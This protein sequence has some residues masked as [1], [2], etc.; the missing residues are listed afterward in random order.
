MTTYTEQ[1]LREYVT[2]RSDKIHADA[3]AAIAVRPK[4]MDRKQMEQELEKSNQRIG[5]RDELAE[6]VDWLNRGGQKQQTPKPKCE[7]CNDTKEVSAPHYSSKG[8]VP[9]CD[10]IKCPKCGV[11]DE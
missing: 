2:Q 5:A 1:E 4:E 3:K 10:F 6:F 8:D 9:D 11:D 7:T